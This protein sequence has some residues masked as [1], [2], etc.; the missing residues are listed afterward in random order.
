MDLRHHMSHGCN[1]LYFVYFVCTFI[2]FCSFSLFL[3][4]CLCFGGYFGVVFFF[5]N[6]SNFHHSCEAVKTRSSLRTNNSHFHFFEHKVI[7]SHH[8]EL[9]GLN[10]SFHVVNPSSIVS[11]VFSPFCLLLVYFLCWCLCMRF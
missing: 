5:G 4:L 2:L 10:I 1:N 7:C 11:T 9:C 6:Y 8:H 3:H